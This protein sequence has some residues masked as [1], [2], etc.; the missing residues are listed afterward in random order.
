MGLLTPVG[1]FIKAAMTIINVVKFFIQRAAQIIELVKAFSDSIKAIANGNVGAVAKAIENALGRAIPVVIG[2]LASLAGL[3]GLADKVVGVIQKIRQRIRNAIVKFWNFVKGKAKKLLGKIGIG[4][5]K[6]KKEKRGKDTR[7]IEEKKRDLY[8]GVKEGTSYLRKN[9]RLKRE[10]V[11]DKLEIISTKYQLVELKLVV[12]KH[13]ETGEDLV[14]LHGKVN[15]EAEGDKIDIN[16]DVDE[17]T[18][19]TKTEIDRLKS[20]N[21]GNKAS[22]ERKT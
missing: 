15:P 9:K 10:T 20:M 22:Y 1:A 16:W 17:K 3:G 12:D 4:D 11:D 13:K 8:E 7:N 6:E 14:H 18:E 19:L 21:G 2:F 5:K